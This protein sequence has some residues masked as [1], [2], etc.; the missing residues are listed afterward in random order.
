[1]YLMIRLLYMDELVSNKIMYILSYLNILLIYLK[2]I[3][4]LK[5]F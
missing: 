3:V 1:M 2:L 5:V 4:L